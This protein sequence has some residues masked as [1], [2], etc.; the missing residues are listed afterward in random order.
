[1][2]VFRDHAPFLWAANLPVVPIRPG[3]KAPVI[4]N[5]SRFC[6]TM[7][8][9]EEREEWLSRYPSHGIGLPLGSA[10][11]LCIVDIDTED[12]EKI[13]AIT[14]A[15]PAS[16]WKRIGKKGMALAFRNPH[17]VRNFSIQGVVDFLATGRQVVLPPT[18]HPDTGRAYT[19]NSALNDRDILAALPDLPADAETRIRQALGVNMTVTTKAEGGRHLALTSEVGRL[20]NRGLTGDLLSAGL[21][22]FNVRVCQP[23][24]PGVEVDAIVSWGDT[25]AGSDPHPLTELGNARRLV[26]RMGGNARHVIEASEWYICDGSIWIPDTDG[27]VERQAKAVGDELLSSAGNNKERRA[28]ALR[29]QSASGIRAMMQLARTEPGIPLSAAKFDADADVINTPSG[30]VDL[31]TGK[32]QP[33]APDA[34]HSRSSAA[35]YIPN[36]P[37]PLFEAFLIQTFL[38]ELTVRFVQRYFGYCL[39]GRTDEQKVNF[40]SGAGANGKSV[41]YNL[42]VGCLGSYAKY[43][44]MSTFVQRRCGSATNDLAALMGVRLVVA[45]EGNPGQ[46]LD[47]ALVKGM[48]GGDPITARFLF[49][50]FVT[51]TPRFKPVIVSNHLPEIDGNDPAIWRRVLVTPFPRVFSDEEQDPRLAEKL[52][53]ELPGILRW[54]VDGAIAYYREGL[55][56]PPTVLRAVAAFRSEMDIIGSFIADCC[57][58]GT[59]LDCPATPLYLAYANYAKQAGAEVMS[60]TA[61][62]R[63]MGRRN[64][65]HFKKAGVIWRRGLAVRPARLGLA[66]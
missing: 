50:E 53:A 22:A 46:V 49:R 26:E 57:I 37:C 58:A 13:D 30:I 35:P 38:D 31:R 45:N 54:A 15:L 48:T 8:S 17:S 3:T 12:P 25:I 21:H 24:L 55:N 33:P 60:Q 39:T 1:M 43:T 19:A 40:A 29:A 34:M 28:A 14:S 62:G 6:E 51:F 16:P 23:P 4:S 9:E 27:H 10:S 41:L 59:G 61:F 63:E 11:G 2:T 32:L 42:I 44:P 65:A 56:P 52:K 64:F 5:W 20:R 18:I 66:A 36:A 47:T 7:P